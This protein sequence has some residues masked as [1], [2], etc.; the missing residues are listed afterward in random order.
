MD[1]D[2]VW[3]IKTDKDAKIMI[4]ITHMDIEGDAVSVNFT[5]LVS[6]QFKK[7]NLFT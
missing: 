2:C 7:I 6:I 4:N 5:K 1:Q 3:I